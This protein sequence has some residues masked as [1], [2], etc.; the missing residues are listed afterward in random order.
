MNL[1]DEYGR[2]PLTYAFAKM[3]KINETSEIDPIQ[4]VS[5][6]C[7]HRDILIDEPD[8]YNRT[9]LHYAARRGSSVSTIYLLKRNAD[10]NSKDIYGNTPLGNSFLSNHNKYAIVLLQANCE[11]NAE[12]YKPVYS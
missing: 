2:T 4:T 1:K 8:I 7:A 10:I 6:Y 12:V 3:G 9:P 5:S 11:I